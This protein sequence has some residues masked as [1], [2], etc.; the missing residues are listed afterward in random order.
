M[1]FTDVSADTGPGA[2]DPHPTGVAGRSPSAFMDADHTATAA[3]A[4]VEI[5]VVDP[6]SFDVDGRSTSGT[7][8]TKTLL[9][10][11]PIN[12][13]WRLP[14]VIVEV[15]DIFGRADGGGCQ[16]INCRARGV[17]ELMYK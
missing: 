4:G 8:E 16:G 6:Q 10:W 9:F 14:L 13:D 1:P 2:D 15:C 11:R 3:R 5:I 12:H 7:S 17:V